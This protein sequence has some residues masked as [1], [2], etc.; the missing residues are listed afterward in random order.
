MA[1]C[2]L[3]LPLRGWGGGWGGYSGRGKSRQEMK[4]RV[5]GCAWKGFIPRSVGFT[6]GNGKLLLTFWE[7]VILDQGVN[8]RSFFCKIPY[9]LGKVGSL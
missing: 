3:V 6:L 1:G 2:G 7:T 5:G 9:L 8:A 4:R